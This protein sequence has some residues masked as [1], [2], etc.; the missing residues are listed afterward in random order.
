[1]LGRV[2]EIISLETV[3]RHLAAHNCASLL[4]NFNAFV[5]DHSQDPLACVIVEH[6]HAEAVL[7]G[8]N[9]CFEQPVAF[10]AQVAWP[11]HDI[12]FATLL[13][14]SERNLRIYMQYAAY[15]TLTSGSSYAY[16][17]VICQLWASSD[18]RP[19]A[20]D[21]MRT[22][23]GLPRALSRP[24]A[25][26][27]SRI[28]QAWLSWSAQYTPAELAAVLPVLLNYDSLEL[29][30][31]WSNRDAWALKEHKT[32]AAPDRLAANNWRWMLSC[33]GNI[34]V[35]S[36]RLAFLLCFSKNNKV[37]EVIKESKKH[38]VDLVKRHPYSKWMLRTQNDRAIARQQKHPHE[39]ECNSEQLSKLWQ[40]LA[41]VEQQQLKMASYILSPVDELG[42]G[43][44][45]H[46][47]HMCLRM[48]DFP[49]ARN[50]SETSQE[51]Y[52][53]RVFPVFALAQQVEIPDRFRFV[54]TLF[55]ERILPSM[56]QNTAN[57]PPTPGIQW[58]SRVEEMLA[59]LTAVVPVPMETTEEQPVEIKKPAEMIET[60]KPVSPPRDPRV[61]PTEDPL[62]HVGT[63]RPSP[64]MPPEQQPPLKQPRKHP[65]PP[66]QQKK[67]R[68]MKATMSLEFNYG[69]MSGDE[70]FPAL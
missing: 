23:C 13:A 30:V 11:K 22:F 10:Y 41:I 59:D 61:R 36:L 56:H 18:S 9:R 39:E 69:S 15:G 66:L 54:R 25:D 57:F 65:P 8:L 32:M 70:L 55:R 42:T 12:P 63:K 58:V 26:D 37:P 7:A 17:P 5:R 40:T 29:P 52:C 16:A 27:I 3:Q 33:A 31:H 48:F 45:F 19:Q 1:M 20:I 60:K 51:E 64:A 49:I 28:R 50:D 47:G 68:T 53:G 62:P 2:Y 43:G 14:L 46:G 35:P 34:I 44:P 21:L 24:D 67:P 4:R 6:T 38:T